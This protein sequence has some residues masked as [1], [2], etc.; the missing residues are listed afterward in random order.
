MSITLLHRPIIYHLHI[1]V[2]VCL[3]WSHT[4][5]FEVM[6][7]SAWFVPVFL[8]F[9]DTKVKCEYVKRPRKKKALFD[10]ERI[11]V[12]SFKEKMYYRNLKY[13]L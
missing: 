1:L 9:S 11:H 10:C 12:L 8:D 7:T 13:K 6:R 2:N 4:L 3:Y 5:N